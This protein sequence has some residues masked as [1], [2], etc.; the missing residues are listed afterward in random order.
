MIIIISNKSN[1]SLTLNTLFSL[2]T[3]QGVYTM[4]MSSRYIYSVVIVSILQSHPNVWPFLEPVNED[5]APDYHE[6]I[7]Y[8]IGKQHVFIKMCVYILMGV[9]VHN[10]R[11]YGMLVERECL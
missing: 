3:A 11:L 9:S 1:N 5:E 4:R 8:P 2:R 10:L 7:K 6:I